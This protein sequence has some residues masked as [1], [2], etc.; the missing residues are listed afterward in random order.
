M[1]GWPNHRNEAAFSY[2]SDVLWIGEASKRALKHKTDSVG[3]T[4]W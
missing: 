3:K 4:H 1:N 2:L